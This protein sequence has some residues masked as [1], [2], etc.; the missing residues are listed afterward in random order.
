MEI[1]ATD[2]ILFNEKKKLKPHNQHKP[3]NIL[4]FVSHTLYIG[5][6]LVTPLHF[7]KALMSHE[8]YVPCFCSLSDFPRIVTEPVAYNSRD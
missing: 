3:P 6:V 4:M 5:M 8:N 1:P 7:S 2:I